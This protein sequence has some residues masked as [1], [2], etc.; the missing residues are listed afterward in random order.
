MQY[1][2]KIIKNAPSKMFTN[3]KYYV[4]AN[5]YWCWSKDKVNINVKQFFLTRFFLDICQ[6]LHVQAFLK[7]RYRAQQ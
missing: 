4:T 5:K 6:I 1:K 2:T 3:N 7:S